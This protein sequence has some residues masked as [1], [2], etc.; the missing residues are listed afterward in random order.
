MTSESILRKISEKCLNLWSQVL[1]SFNQS[2]LYLRYYNDFNNKK[3]RDKIYDIFE[4]Q[5]IND[6]KSFVTMLIEKGWQIIFISRNNKFKS[7]SSPTFNS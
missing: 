6:P 4:S 2:K 5:K 3:I 7:T 1:K